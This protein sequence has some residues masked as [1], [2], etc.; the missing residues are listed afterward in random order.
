MKNKVKTKQKDKAKKLL[1]RI[2][3]LKKPEQVA[4]EV[5]LLEPKGNK[6]T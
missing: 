1:N 2:N 4:K 3:F 5:L 6:K